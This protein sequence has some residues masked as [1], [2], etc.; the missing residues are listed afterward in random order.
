LI[1]FLSTINLNFS[2]SSAKMVDFP[3]FH[4]VETYLEIIFDLYELEPNVAIM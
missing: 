4:Q 1:L 2:G 3:F